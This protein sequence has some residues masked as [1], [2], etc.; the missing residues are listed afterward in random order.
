MFVIV[1]VFFVGG[2][3]GTQGNA[4]GA[5]GDTQN[6]NKNNNI[7]KTTKKRT[8]DTQSQH[9]ARDTTTTQQK[10]TNTH[11]QYNQQTTTK[12]AWDLFVVFLIGEQKWNAGKHMGSTR[13]HNN[14]QQKTIP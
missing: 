7:P 4:W 14:K 11:E 12:H 9:T 13:G 5:R 8:I 3:A 6:N 1:G 2:K 10:Q